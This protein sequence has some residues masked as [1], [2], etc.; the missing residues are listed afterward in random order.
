M[1][2]RRGAWQGGP[3]ERQDAAGDR[4]RPEELPEA[5]ARIRRI[6]Q[7][8]DGE[9]ASASAEEHCEL[10][11]DER[12]ED[13]I[14]D[15]EQC[16]PLAR[17]RPAGPRGPLRRRVERRGRER[18]DREQGRERCGTEPQWE[19]VG[20]DGDGWEI[21]RCSDVPGEGGVGAREQPEQ[22][23][24][25]GTTSSSPRAM[26]PAVPR[27]VRIKRTGGPARLAAPSGTASSGI[28][29]TRER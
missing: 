6:R 3:G 22:R 1:A 12:G 11:G 16:N 24:D 17:A 19:H 28:Q 20:P 25:T 13:A 5:T 10:H 26:L 4:S 15:H 7:P 23:K 27:F 29:N 14:D 8:F 21:D 9:H 2:T 18:R